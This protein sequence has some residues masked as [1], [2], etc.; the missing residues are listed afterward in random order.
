MADEEYPKAGS[1]TK[2]GS[3]S[4]NDVLGTSSGDTSDLDQALNSHEGLN[5]YHAQTKD[6]L[7]QINSAINTVQNGTNPAAPTSQAPLGTT[8]ST[9]GAPA[10]VA[11]FAG[12]IQPP[13]G[14]N[15]YEGPDGSISYDFNQSV[16]QTRVGKTGNG[17]IG[18][19]IDG[20][21]SLSSA[22]M[23]S[24]NDNEQFF[25]GVHGAATANDAAF[26]KTFP[27]SATAQRLDAIAAALP[28][29]RG[30]P[31][32]SSGGLTLPPAYNRVGNSGR[33]YGNGTVY[34]PYGT[35]SRNPIAGV[36]PGFTGSVFDQDPKAAQTAN[37]TAASL[38]IPLSKARPFN[39]DNTFPALPASRY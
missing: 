21:A 20:R 26:G 3:L 23:K 32:P 4:V 9:S 14:M 34:S 13:K 8:L 1:D 35:V 5:D 25:A 24:R 15:A 30:I 31:Q 16:P 19:N 17:L 33:D 6:V 18:G 10:S 7:A 12:S 11:P 39:A 38:A 28:N 22:E 27:A 36:N 29:N 2:T 37:T